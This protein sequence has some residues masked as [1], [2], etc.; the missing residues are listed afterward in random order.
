M[1]LVTIQNKK[2]LYKL[3]NG[4]TYLNDFEY[5]IKEDK[6]ANYITPQEFAEMSRIKAYQVL[7]R[8]YGFTTPP[9]F[10]CVPN[11]VV[12]FTGTTPKNNILLEL[13]VPNDMIHVHLFD[14]WKHIYHSV[15]TKWWC[16]TLYEESKDYL[17]G[18]DTIYNLH[19]IQ[20][21]IPY[22]LPEWLLSA[23]KVY[24]GFIDKYEDKAL[25]EYN[26]K[27]CYCIYPK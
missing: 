20:A 2:V 23:Y 16:D 15:Y 7:M 5:I 17:D 8:H 18:K 14:T 9:I 12:N 21:V 11:R 13:E 22:I 3:I 1:K 19:S 4:H 10:C 24:D 26:Y 27:C 6:N 25:F